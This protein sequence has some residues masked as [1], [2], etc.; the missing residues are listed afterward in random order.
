[1]DGTLYAFEEKLRTNLLDVS[2]TEELRLVIA[3][4]G[5]SDSLSLLFALDNL[6]ESLNLSI[7]G[8]HINHGVRG[9][10]SLA[11]SKFVEKIFKKLEI[12]FMIGKG[13]SYIEEGSHSNVSENFLRNERFE[14]LTKALKKF[15]A[16]FIAL[17]HTS[18]DQVETVLMNLIRGTGIKGL[19][20]KSKKK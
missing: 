16:H 4:S 7:F 12:P 3:V 17:G 15:D 14:F 6:S 19:E 9:S 5:G 11:D 1:M 2:S 18:D 13:E 20:G 8:A 10:D